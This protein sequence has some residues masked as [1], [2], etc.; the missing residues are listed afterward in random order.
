MPDATIQPQQIQVTIQP[1]TAQV[2]IQPQQFTAA[3][4]T[5]ATGAIAQTQAAQATPQPQTVTVVTAAQQGPSGPPGPPGPGGGAATKIA[6]AYGDA[7]PSPVATIAADTTIF[8][9]LLS[10]QTPFNGVGATLQLG[11]AT[12]SDRLLAAN[13]CDLTQAAEYESNPGYTYSS[14]T[15]LL[16]TINPGAGCTRGAG[17]ILLEV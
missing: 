5:Q 12:S 10:V 1:Q 2:T 9:V 13:Q 7:S 4:T 8:T 16:L 17:Y 14:S 3:V 11:D 6:F 15:A